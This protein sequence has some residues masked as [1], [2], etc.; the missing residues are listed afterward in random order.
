M[1]GRAALESHTSTL[2]PAVAHKTQTDRADSGTGTGAGAGVPGDA[3]SNGDA[4]QRRAVEAAPAGGGS[5]NSLFGWLRRAET[6]DAAGDVNDQRGE[7][8]MLRP[9]D[10]LSHVP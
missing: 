3:S 1:R 4:D 8:A 5:L 9:W 7:Q 10:D 2:S 6:P